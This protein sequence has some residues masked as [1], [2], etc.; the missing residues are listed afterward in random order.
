MKL[1]DFACKS[2]GFTPGKNKISN[3]IVGGITTFLTMSYILAVN[4]GIFSP[5]AALGMDTPA[6]FTATALAAIVGTLLMAFI[7]KMPIALA[8]GMGMNAFFVYTVCLSMGY[9]WR[10]ALTAVFIEGIIFVLLTALN[11]R[12]LIID[13]IPP[14]I[15]NSIGV[16]V[17]L[18]IALIGLENCGIVVNN[19]DTIVSLGDITSGSA[20]LALIGIIITAAMMAKKVPCALLI[21][22]LVTT[23]IGIPMGITKWQGVFSTPPSIS[24]IF[25]QFEWDNILCPDMI[26]VVATLLFMDIFDTMGSLVAVCS[27]TGMIQ[28]DGSIPNANKAFMADSLATVFGA[29]F[30]TN[31]TTTYVESATGTSA[32]GRTGLT[33]VVTAICFALSLFMAPLFLAVPGAATAPA[34]VIVGLMMLRE[35]KTVNLEDPQDAVPAFITILT[36]PLTYSISNGIMLGII[37]YTLINTLCGNIRKVGAP[38]WVLAVL[39][40]CKF[41]FL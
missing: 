8:P 4:P 29:I 14:A 38:M 13:A 3:E 40:I 18:F 10:F 26:I 21:G 15:K 31:T 5:L 23:L 22:I 41:A 6:V 11:I 25:C 19:P 34:L 16:G 32:G 37:A 17:G 27:Q 30:G 24:G 36:I 7:A 33:A 9:S 28:K 1:T 35:I 20:L 12:S 2:L 39:F